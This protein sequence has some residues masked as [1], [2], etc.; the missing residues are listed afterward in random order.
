MIRSHRKMQ[1]VVLK[2]EVTQP[3]D[4]Q[5]WIVG[6]SKF[7]A[8]L[9]QE[10]PDCSLIKEERE[11]FPLIQ[12]P[13]K[14][15]GNVD[16][17][18]KKPG[19]CVEP[20]TD[21]CCS[22]DS[23]F[24]KETRER[25]SPLKT[26]KHKEYCF[27]EEVGG[28]SPY[29]EDNMLGQNLC[30]GRRQ[31]SCSVCRTCILSEHL[32]PHMLHTVT[33]PSRFCT[34]DRVFTWC[35]T[36]KH[37]QRVKQHHQIQTQKDCGRQ[38]CTR[39]HPDSPPGPDPPDRTSD[40]SSNVNNRMRTHTDLQQ[41][42]VGKSK[43]SASLNQEEP[44]CSHIKEEREEFPLIRIPVKNYGNVDKEE[45]KPGDCVEP[46]TDDCC[47]VDS[48]F[49]KE[50]RER[51]SP[52]K[53]MKHKEYCFSEEVG[54]MSPYNEDNMLGQNL[55][56]GRRQ[57]SCSVCRTCILSEEHLDPHMLHTVTKPSRFCT[58]DKVF[59]WCETL[60]QH[61][62][63]KQHHQI[64][65]QKDCGRQLC[66]RSHP[67]SPPGPDPP[68]R[69]SDCSNNVKNHMRTHTGHQQMF[70][71]K[72]KVHDQQDWSFRLKKPVPLHHNEEQEFPLTGVIVKKDVDEALH[73]SEGNRGAEPPT[74]HFSDGPD[75]DKDPH[76]HA[77]VRHQDLDSECSEP[78]TDQ[79]DDDCK[80]AGYPESGLKS[81]SQDSDSRFNAGEKMLSCSECKKT[82]GHK[83]H[84]KRHMR[85]HTGEKPF[86]CADC[87]KRFGQKTNL[88]MHIR[89]H[90]G[91]KPYSCPFCGKSCTHKTNLTRHL[92]VHTGEKLF[93]CN[94]CRKEFS[95]K[96]HFKNHKCVHVSN[97]VP[98]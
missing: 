56:I 76:P 8:S 62:R 9:N 89:I 35:E 42:I 51:H 4:W 95:R 91:E 2:D 94:V 93:R 90:T 64:Q 43:F 1:H 7:P 69:T 44:Y 25:H 24:W 97:F 22:V 27:S 55:C 45:K 20:Q 98:C 37:H 47:S 54:G 72:C 38:L 85:T 32:D 39:S 80:E 11:E 58:Y 21:D 30:T 15:D 70:L 66:T 19:D 12:I 71:G 59:T 46:Q 86:S 87:G 13:V 33:K 74:S 73:H 84:L 53:T 23:D 65:T 67:D 50:T 6:K 81:F 96:E 60:K 79:S 14:N 3:R 10:E 16:K 68:D 5:Q 48:D 29:N 41:W 77:P 36:L 82:F 61:Q 63:V 49:W 40:C 52:L 31:T 75:P 28:M 88:N 26:M 57:T 18:E 34:C 78:E 17:E 83:G 92:M